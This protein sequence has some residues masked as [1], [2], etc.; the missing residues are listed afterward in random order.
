MCCQHPQQ[1]CSMSRERSKCIAK[2]LQTSHIVQRHD[3]PLLCDMS[4]QQ[5]KLS[6]A[7]TYSQQSMKCCSGMQPHASL[8]SSFHL[9]VFMTSQ[10]GDP[11]PDPF[12]PGGGIDPTHPPVPIPAA[13]AATLQRELDTF[14][15]IS[16]SARPA[17]EVPCCEL[18]NAFAC[19]D[20][21]MHRLLSVHI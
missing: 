16:L 14:R 3:S 18:P 6:P 17:F 20:T 15:Q 2:V 12:T 9:T 4:C 8:A 21:L 19:C 11:R 13:S 7:N 10:P 5:L 1:C